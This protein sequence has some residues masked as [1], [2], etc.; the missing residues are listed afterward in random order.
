M[1]KF[2]F[3]K[4]CKFFPNVF[5]LWYVC[6]TTLAFH[7]IPPIIQLSVLCLDALDGFL[8]QQHLPHWLTH[9]HSNIY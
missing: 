7:L 6:A 9:I 4:I 2:K 1:Y 3:T 8:S 5:N